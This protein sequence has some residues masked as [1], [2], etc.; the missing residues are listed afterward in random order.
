VDAVRDAEVDLLIAD[1][2]REGDRSMLRALGDA[3]AKITAPGVRRAVLPPVLDR[4]FP[5]FDLYAEL[6]VLGAGA[7][8]LP[9]LHAALFQLARDGSAGALKS[10]HPAQALLL[11]LQADPGFKRSPILLALLWS[12]DAPTRQ[13][14]LAETGLDAAQVLQAT[15]V[16]Q[17]CELVPSIGKEAVLRSLPRGKEAKEARKA[18]PALR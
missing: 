13:R 10:L 14:V 11:D 2:A 16:S 1:R 18:C 15:P 5:D 12:A 17:R 8:D 7:A 6:H 3:G 9:P 4:S